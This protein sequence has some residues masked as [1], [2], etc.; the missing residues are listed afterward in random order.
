M[1]SRDVTDRREHA[2][3]AEQRR[4]DL[5][6][7]AADS[8]LNHIIKGPCEVEQLAR[9]SVTSP[10]L[11]S[12]FRLVQVGAVRRLSTPHLAPHDAETG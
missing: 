7:R 6:N 8:R 4:V 5:E 3:L 12:W 10:R 1:I 9:L 2:R 11:V